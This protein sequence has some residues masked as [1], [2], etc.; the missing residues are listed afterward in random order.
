MSESHRRNIHKGATAGLRIVRPQT[1][2]EVAAWPDA[3]SAPVENSRIV[4]DRMRGPRLFES[5][6]SSNA[7]I[8][9][10]ALRD[11][12]PVAMAVFLVHN[13]AAVYV[14]GALDR[15]RAPAGSHHFLIAEILRELNEMKIE[16]VDLGSGPGG[17]NEPGLAQF[18]RGWGAQP[19]SRR[20]GCYRRGWY[21]RLRRI[22]R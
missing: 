13:R 20:T 22:I 5:F 7:L 10:T 6:Q 21:H 2:Q 14:D 4:L 3:W 8:W 15:E 16:I 18:K 12:R 17:S 11:D 19:Q 9:R 1:V